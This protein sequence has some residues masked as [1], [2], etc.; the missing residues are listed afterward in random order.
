[1]PAPA[2][3]RNQTCMSSPRNTRDVQ[4]ALTV[5]SIA[6]QDT[7]RMPAGNACEAAGCSGVSSAH[8]NLI[9]QRR[10]DAFQTNFQTLSAVVLV[11]HS[12]Y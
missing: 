3:I 1:M 5:S 2:G 9:N 10:I 6:Q 11:V 12:A 4:T 7:P 8:T